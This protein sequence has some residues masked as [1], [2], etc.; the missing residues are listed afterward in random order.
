MSEHKLAEVLAQQPES[1]RLWLLV[2]AQRKRLGLAARRM[3]SQGGLLALRGVPDLS[4]DLMMRLAHGAMLAQGAESWTSSLDGHRVH[5]YAFA[6]HGDGPPLL[7][8]HGLGGSASSVA[9]LVPSL[10]PLAP[11]VVLLE[12][13]GHGRSP[14]PARGPLNAR[15][16]G[17]V[18]IACAEEMAREQGGKVVLVGNSLGGAL[19]LYTAHERPDLAAGVVGLNPAGA[20]LSDEAMNALP[21]AFTDANTGA[22]R[23]ARLLFYRTPW[24]FWLVARDFARHWG[25][26]TV[27][28]ILDDARAGSDRSLGLDVLTDI[29]VPVLIL[30]GAQDRL[31]PPSSLED[32]RRIAGARVETLQ[33]CGHLPQLER[34]AATRRAVAEFVRGLKSSPPV[35]RK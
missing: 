6:G 25:T 34:P 20:E 19:A 15:E 28:R 21:R 7:L 13:P 14:E 33:G 29:H 31:L 17:G 18:V 23:M 10:L 4:L 26:P 11:R 16:Y 9:P 5:R 24:T 3:L 1:G 27:Q 22:A 8:L 32:F 2:A 35:R 12:L 30:W